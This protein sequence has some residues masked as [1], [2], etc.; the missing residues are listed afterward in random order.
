[1]QTP[2]GD[3]FVTKR[4]RQNPFGGFEEQQQGQH[5]KTWV[6]N[7][8]EMYYRQGSGE[9]AYHARLVDQCVVLGLSAQ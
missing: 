5:D 6:E 9:G 4:P 8:G 3:I 7:L 1:M 2:G